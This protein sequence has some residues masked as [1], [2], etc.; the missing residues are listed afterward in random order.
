M[1][2]ITGVVQVFKAFSCDGVHSLTPTLLG[3]RSKCHAVCA[4]IT[5]LIGF[6][7]PSLLFR[8]STTFDPFTLSVPL[9][10]GASTIPPH[11]THHQCHSDDQSDAEDLLD[12]E[13][14]RR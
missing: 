13:L 7:M 2:P 1:M 12:H 14:K 9:K 3:E 11:L 4:E 10:A 5:S 8:T 6:R